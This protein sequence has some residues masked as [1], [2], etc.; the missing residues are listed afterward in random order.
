MTTVWPRSRRDPPPGFCE[1]TIPADFE[2]GATTTCTAKPSF[3]SSWTACCCCRPTTAGTIFPLLVSRKTKSQRSKPTIARIPSAASHGQTSLPGG[4]G[5]G[6]PGG[7]TSS[8]GSAPGGAPG[9]GPAGGP[10]GGAGGG[11]GV[12]GGC[13]CVSSIGRC[14]S[15]MSS[16]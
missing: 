16:S 5:G 14:G 15:V 8:G 11:G 3:V 13:A 12:T 4:P 7:G 1:K 6:A 10:G 2:D 9:G